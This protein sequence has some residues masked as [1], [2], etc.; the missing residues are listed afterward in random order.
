MHVAD[1]PYTSFGQYLQK[2]YGEHI[3][4]LSLNASFTCPNRDGTKGI[5]GCTFCNNAS[6]SPYAK[7]NPSRQ[8]T[9]SIVEQMARGRSVIIKRTGAKKYLGYFQAYTNTYDEVENLKRLYD[10]AL[11]AQDVVG[12][13]IGTRPDCVPDAVIDLLLSYQEQ[14]H[15][16]WLELGLQS[17]FD[18]SLKR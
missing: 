15:E 17:A 10:Q 5:G 6:F 13:S 3:H 1:R 14:G 9:D 18:E 11:C 4:K 16:I 2:L 12:L 7:G 8:K